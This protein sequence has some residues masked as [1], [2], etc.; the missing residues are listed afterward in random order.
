MLAAL[1][2]GSLLYASSAAAAQSPTAAGASCTFGAADREWT[3]HALDA[4]ERVNT[5]RL[6]I[7]AVVLPTL[8]LFDDACTHTFRPVEGASVGAGFRAGAH[9]FAVTSVSHGGQVS[10]PGGDQMPVGVTSFASADSGGR[11]FFVMSLPAIWQ[12]RVQAP[13]PI[14]LATLVFIHE[15]THSQSPGLG[16]AIGGLIARGLPS[17]I[18]DDIVQTRFAGRPGF[19]AAYEGERDLL[20]QAA[21]APGVDAAR[22]L[23]ADALRLMERRRQQ[24][25]TGDDLVYADAEAVF[26]TMEGVAQWAAYRWL[27]DPAGGATTPEDALPL[28]RR[29]G[30]QWSQDM[31]LALMLVLDRLS[32]DWP[33]RLLGPKPVTAVDLLES[34]AGTP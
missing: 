22:S 21:V 9:A 31:G 28:M 10:L 15:F 27:I 12:A 19:Q 29:G 5:A 17:E 34:V 20:Y 23:A 18:D 16:E 6:N 32:P 25:F 11:M 33:E 30:R 8:V 3:R 24:F 13:D 2:V 7:K 1:V 4:W 14:E 26:L